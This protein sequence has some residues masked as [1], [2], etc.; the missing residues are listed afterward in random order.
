MRFDIISEGEAAI[1]HL[2]ETR[3]WQHVSAR[4]QF[5]EGILAFCRREGEAVGVVE[6]GLVA[7]LP[8][9]LAGRREDAAE[10][11]KV[12]LQRVQQ[13]RVAALRGDMDP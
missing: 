1:G 11:G 10:T 4:E 6:G 5:S 3:L 12:F 13:S 7:E 2:P 8:L 9:L